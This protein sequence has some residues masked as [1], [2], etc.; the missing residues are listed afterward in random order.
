MVKSLLVTTL[1]SVSAL[2]QT[3]A[4]VTKPFSDTAKEN[5]ITLSQ[6]SVAELVLK[7]GPH[8]KEVD[9]SYQQQLL[10]PV[11]VLS[12]YDWILNAATGYSYDK[13]IGLLSTPA[14]ID[15]KYEQYR[16]TVGLTKPFLTGTKMDLELSRISQK[17][18][19]NAPG[20]SLLP[21][22]QQT[23]DSAGILLEQAIL[24]NFFG[25][26]DRATVNAANLTYDATALLRE[27]DLEDV[28]L[29]SLRLFWNSYV[30]QENF[31]EA[32]ASRD[33]NKKL[34]DAVKRKT[35]LGYTNPGDLAQAL[36]EFEGKEQAV[37]IASTN[38]LANL[39][40][41][42]TFLGLP[43]KTDIVFDVPK[44]IPPIPKLP[45][46]NVEELRSIQSQKKKVDSAQESLTAAESNSYPTLNLVGQL[47]TTGNG[48]T[49]E[50]SFSQT[51]SGTAPKYYVGL[52]F[53]YNFG[54]DIQNETI[55][56][57]KLNK[58]LEETRLQRNYSEAQ[59]LQSQAERKANSSYEVAVSA[60]RQINYRE[61]AMQELT[62]SYNQGRTDISILITAMNNYFSADLAYI[63]AVGDYQIA[64]NEWASARDE[65]IPTQ[66]KK[67]ES[68]SK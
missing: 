45:S 65:L 66:H 26:A 29:Q 62:K 6:K 64:L 35:S 57:N 49:S 33:R 37:K 36:A 5:T 54:S 38:Y 2:A 27:N 15:Q 32:V 50:A 47:Y 44:N 24:G 52:R 41:L 48:T 9:L 16:T 7:Q 68:N 25:V 56:Y 42:L 12:A 51:T 1:F 21:P 59:D 31:K 63:Q 8:A 19:I 61:K 53:Q 58:T 14:P 3:A 40:N 13:S 22:P 43:A 10:A 17:A 67:E 18:D 30:S 28:V 55:V 11:K 23:A 4:P 20:D 46:K 39:E 60:E 34:V